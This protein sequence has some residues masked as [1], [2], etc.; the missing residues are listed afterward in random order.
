MACSMCSRRGQYRLA[1]LAA[2]YGSEI[3]M[4]TFSNTLLAIAS[5][6]VRVTRITR[7]AVL[8]CDLGLGKPPPDLPPGVVLCRPNRVA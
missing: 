5:G 6:G 2:K 3:E 1:R 7:A 8:F 4:P